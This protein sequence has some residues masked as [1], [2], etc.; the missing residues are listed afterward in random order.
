MGLSKSNEMEALKKCDIVCWMLIMYADGFLATKISDRE[1]RNILL[2][3][4]DLTKQI[5]WV[6]Y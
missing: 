4:I 5:L 3:I 2:T 6:F 1:I